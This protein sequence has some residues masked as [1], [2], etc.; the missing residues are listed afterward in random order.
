MRETKAL[1]GYLKMNFHLQKVVCVFIGK[2]HLCLIHQFL[3]FLIFPALYMMVCKNSKKCFAKKS[4][5]VPNVKQL[6]KTVLAYICIFAGYDT[7]HFA[8]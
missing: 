3:L 5:N 4:L 6:S 1:Y 2:G 8:H 7:L